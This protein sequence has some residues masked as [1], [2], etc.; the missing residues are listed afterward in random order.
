MFIVPGHTALCLME[1]MVNVPHSNE[2]YVRTTPS[3][4]SLWEDAHCGIIMFLTSCDNSMNMQRCE[5]NHA[6]S[7]YE[8]FEDH[9]TYVMICVI[10]VHS[11]TQLW[12]NMFLR[13][14]LCFFIFI[15]IITS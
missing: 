12:L 6:L 1:A 4:W 8:A 3:V 7:M 5:G 13:D 9:V 2:V 15:D 10:C 11:H 14:F